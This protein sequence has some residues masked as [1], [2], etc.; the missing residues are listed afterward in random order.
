[1]AAT[2][3]ATLATNDT[4]N[5][6]EVDISATLR[7]ILRTNNINYQNANIMIDGNP[8]AADDLDKTLEQLD[9]TDN[10]TVAVTVKIQNA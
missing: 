7:S 3:N 10:P 6:T 9:A 2:T 8:I 1:M 4:R 5:T